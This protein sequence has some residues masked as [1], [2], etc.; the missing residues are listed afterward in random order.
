MEKE[1]REVEYWA[2]NSPLAIE[3][4]ESLLERGLKVNHIFTG[5]TLPILKDG[6]NYTIGVGNI[7][8]SYQLTPLKSQRQ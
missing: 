3:I 4:R 6:N 8:T 7:L 5:S 1:K 2:N